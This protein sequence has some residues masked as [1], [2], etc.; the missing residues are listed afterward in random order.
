MS[1]V[2]ER[3]ERSPQNNWISYREFL[4]KFSYIVKNVFFYFVYVL[5]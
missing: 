1:K 5:L 2:L 4:K 3:T